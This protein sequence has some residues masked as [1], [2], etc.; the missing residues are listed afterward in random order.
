MME[1]GRESSDMTT[2]SHSAVEP[3]GPIICSTQTMC[4]SNDFTKTDEPC[5]CVRAG[6]DRRHACG[7]RCD[8][9]DD[10]RRAG[11]AREYP[12]LSRNIVGYAAQVFATDTFRRGAI[13]GSPRRRRPHG[14]SRGLSGSA[15]HRAISHAA[16]AQHRRASAR[17]APRRARAALDGALVAGASHVR[18][19]VGQDALRNDAGSG[20]LRSHLPLVR[21][22]RLSAGHLSSRDRGAR[23]ASTQCAAF[24][25]AR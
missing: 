24:Q 9:R 21:N 2:S 11:C 23:M 18:E 10:R 13:G 16:R 4:R 15:I 5:G 19:A 6:G 8:E 22:R 7:D 12:C 17:G 1:N 3:G 20:A 25:V 14:T